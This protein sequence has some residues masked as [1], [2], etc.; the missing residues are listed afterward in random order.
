MH[1]NVYMYLKTHMHTQ[2]HTKN[3]QLESRLTIDNTYTHT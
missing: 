1:I 3:T 2:A